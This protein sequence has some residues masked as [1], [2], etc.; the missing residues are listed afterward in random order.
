VNPPKADTNQNLVD[1]LRELNILRGEIVSMAKR[2]QLYDLRCEM[3][4]CYCPHGRSH[5]VPRTA[6]M[7][8]WA[9]NAD[10]YP[11]LKTDGGTL[12][13]GNIRLA[14]V[15]CNNLDY[16]W[17]L[18]IR[19]MLDEGLSLEEIAENLNRAKE[20]RAPHGTGS[21]TAARVRKAYVS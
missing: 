20:V 19:K 3:P 21:W 4:T 14:H 9:L 1:R 18:R 16:G 8:K 10:H 15:W 2:G 17:R 12:T 7:H 11:K 6:P 13:A 5:F